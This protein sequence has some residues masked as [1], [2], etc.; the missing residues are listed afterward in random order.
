VTIDTESHQRVLLFLG[1]NRLW[2]VR[3]LGLGERSAEPLLHSLRG[4][5]LLSNDLR[6][7]LLHLHGVWLWRL[8]PVFGCVVQAWQFL[9]S[10]G[11]GVLAGLILKRLVNVPQR[12]F[13][14]ELLENFKFLSVVVQ[15]FR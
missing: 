9:L 8:H 15:E 10:S 5:F 6:D 13:L 3:L 4:D 12:Y 7:L 14:L 1:G 11:N 2:Q